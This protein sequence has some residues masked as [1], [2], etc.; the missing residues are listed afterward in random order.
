MRIKTRRLARGFQ[1]FERLHELIHP[2][3]IG[4]ETNEGPAKLPTNPQ[5]MALVE[6]KETTT[7]AQEVKS[8]VRSRNDAFDGLKT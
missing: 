8:Q 4:L 3:G 2:E 6:M 7:L 1:L 5:N